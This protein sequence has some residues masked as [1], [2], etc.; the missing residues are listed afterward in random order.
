MGNFLCVSEQDKNFELI[1]VITGDNIP[2]KMFTNCSVGDS[3]FN[4][5]QLSAHKSGCNNHG[6]YTYGYNRYFHFRTV[7]S[8]IKY[9]T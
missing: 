2:L 4:M 8:S 9:Y 3:N 1:F 5:Q 6:H 7:N